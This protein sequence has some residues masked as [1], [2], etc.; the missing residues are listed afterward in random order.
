MHTAPHPLAGVKIL[1]PRDIELPGYKILVGEAVTVRDWFD[2]LR[3]QSW[4][5]SDDMD[6]YFYAIHAAF[7]DLPADDNVVV[8]SVGSGQEFLVHESEIKP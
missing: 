5:F 1:S 2:T 6:A 7:S 3:E 4:M 8:I